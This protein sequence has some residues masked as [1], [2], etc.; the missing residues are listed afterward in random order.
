MLGVTYLLDKDVEV[1]LDLDLVDGLD[2]LELLI[3]AG[4]QLRGGD[5][6]FLLRHRQL[7]KQKEVM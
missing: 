7:S 4:A 2:L 5:F 6:S 1:L 3:Q